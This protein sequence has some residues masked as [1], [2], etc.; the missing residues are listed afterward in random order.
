ML[1]L[2]LLL[3]MVIH[4]V[5]CAD[6]HVHKLYFLH[7][8]FLHCTFCRLEALVYVSIIESQYFFAQYTLLHLFYRLKML[9][10]T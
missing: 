1:E 7:K 9:N 5:K 3:S 4:Y 2:E 6:F 10:F 8:L